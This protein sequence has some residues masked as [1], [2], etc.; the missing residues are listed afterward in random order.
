MPIGQPDSCPHE[1]LAERLIR[2]AMDEGEFDGLAGTGR[3]ISGRGTTDDDLWWV[4][5][6]VRRNTAPT[7]DPS[8]S[9]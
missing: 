2:E 5:S 1:P 7:Q 9:E 4:R 8:S 6:W 3:P